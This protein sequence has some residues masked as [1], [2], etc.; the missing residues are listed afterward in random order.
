MPTPASQDVPAPVAAEGTLA[1]S[2]RP[3]I[4]RFLNVREVEAGTLAPDGTR[5]SYITNTT[6][7]PQLWTAG[8]RGG[9]PAQV[10]FLES[11]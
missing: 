5:L 8:A 11:V 1:G 9:A 2:A 3:D 7:Q 4:A 6:G 10:T